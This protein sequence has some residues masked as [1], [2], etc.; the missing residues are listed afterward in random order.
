M[1]GAVLLNPDDPIFTFEHMMAH[2]NYFAVM[3]TSG[4]SVLPY[5]LDPSYD[6]NIPASPWH[7]NHQQAHNDYNAALPPY[8]DANAVGFGIPQNQI[9]IDSNLSNPDQLSWW[10]F[11]NHQEHYIANNA[12]LPLGSEARFP[13]W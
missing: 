1:P 3:E 4:Y 11:I 6:T 12:I 5:L 8:W 10:T 9:L 13:F 2:R 7:Q